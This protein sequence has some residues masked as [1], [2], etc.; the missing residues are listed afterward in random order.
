MIKNTLNAKIIKKKKTDC[1]VK[2]E[3]RKRVK[4]LRVMDEESLV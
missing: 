4:T 3:I 1:K 2:G